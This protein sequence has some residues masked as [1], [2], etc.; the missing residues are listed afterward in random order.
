MSC[1]QVFG[2]PESLTKSMNRLNL[3]QSLLTE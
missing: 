2:Q 1:F 3:Y